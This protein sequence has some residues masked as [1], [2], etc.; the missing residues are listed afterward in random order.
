MNNFTYQCPTKIVFGKD[1]IKELKGLLPEGKK[2]LLVYGGGSIKKNGVYDAV[3]DALSSCEYVEFCGIE[4]NPK[5]ETCMKAVELGRREN[6]DFILS[7]GGGSVLDGVKFIS[8]AINHKGDEWEIV[9][10]G[11]SAVQCVVPI[12]NV[13][14]IPATGSEMNC[15]SVISHE[16]K[17]LKSIFVNPLVYPQFSIIDPEVTYTLPLRQTRN[18]IIDTI[19]HVMEQYCTYEVNSPV[20][21]GFS[22][23]VIKAIMKNAPIVLENPNDYDARANI[24]WAATCGLNGWCGLGV[25]QDWSSHMIGHELTAFYGLDHGQSLAIVLPRLLRYNIEQ[26]KVKLALLGREVFGLTGDDDTVASTCIDK[27]YEF[28]ASTGVN[29]KLE[30][31][32]IDSK[33]AAKKIEQKFIDLDIKAG[34]HQNIDSNAAREILLEC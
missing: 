16:E 4:P 25:V 13:M 17:G 28:F 2:V 10:S 22:F 8:A 11:G 21:D 23:S 12:G 33:E 26:K 3:K 24:F 14:T 34:E 6:I 30:E 32:G 1:T 9:S 18:G 7:V 20:V 29:M 31:Y 19:V 5:Y 15:I 27:L